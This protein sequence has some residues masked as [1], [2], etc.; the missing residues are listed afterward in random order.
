MHSLLCFENCYHSQ[1][2]GNSEEWEFSGKKAIIY[3]AA[4]PGPSEY[5]LSPMSPLFSYSPSHICLSNSGNLFNFPAM[6]LG[7]EIL[8]HGK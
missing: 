7:F 3:G 1:R 8:M 2:G 6:S 4:P 5:F